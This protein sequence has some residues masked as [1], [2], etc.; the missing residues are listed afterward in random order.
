MISVCSNDA[1]IPFLFRNPRNVRR[2][3]QNHGRMCYRDG[4]GQNQC[5]QPN[6]LPVSSV[7]SSASSYCRLPERGLPLA[8]LTV[9]LH[10]SPLVRFHSL[11][12]LP[13]V[14]TLGDPSVASVAVPFTEHVGLDTLS[15]FQTV[16]IHTSSNYEPLWTRARNPSRVSRV[17]RA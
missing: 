8:L 2:P 10:S 11:V 3:R 17:S 14:R 6:L 15:A 5:S 12:R 4:G 9:L 7:G 1:A 13:C 16:Q